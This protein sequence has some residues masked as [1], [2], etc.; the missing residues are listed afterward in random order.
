[1]SLK[2][3]L[4]DEFDIN[5]EKKIIMQGEYAAE[6]ERLVK[7][8]KED[9]KREGNEFMLDGRGG[10]EQAQ[11]LVEITYAKKLNVPLCYGNNSEIA[12]AGFLG[13]S[14]YRDDEEGLFA[15]FGDRVDFRLDNRGNLF[16]L[17][18]NNQKI[19]KVSPRGVV[20]TVLEI[21]VGFTGGFYVDHDIDLLLT[22]VL[23][24][25]DEIIFVKDNC[26]MSTLCG[27]LQYSYTPNYNLWDVFTATSSDPSVALNEYA[28]DT[29]LTPL[30]DILCT[31]QWGISLIKGRVADKDW[32]RLYDV[33]KS[34]Q[35][36]IYTAWMDRNSN[37]WMKVCLH[38]DENCDLELALVK[39]KRIQR[40][41]PLGDDMKDI[42]VSD[43]GRIFAVLLHKHIIEIFQNGTYHILK[44]LCVTNATIP[45]FIGRI[46]I[47][48]NFTGLYF[49]EGHQ[50][51][52]IRFPVVL[53]EQTKYSF[54]AEQRKVIATVLLIGGKKEYK[55][56]LSDLP[57]EIVR[58]I[59]S[60]MEF[61]L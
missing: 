11:R 13:R 58:E 60:F 37:V 28:C 45:K 21:P 52:K 44:D 41:I 6:T 50:I 23:F 17:D 46:K 55:N 4:Y 36:D 53:N 31:D 54:R 30:G 56:F 49:L 8:W 20:T 12:I 47:I 34:M 3:S 2:K 7:K 42:H 1:M 48:A 57:K 19:R 40:T 27:V 39:N 33:P 61:Y 18:W 10:L 29:F 16:I 35:C 9:V 15:L 59:A 5:F 26:L 25:D 22:D 32:S 43:D 51:R 24:K 14:G 38:S